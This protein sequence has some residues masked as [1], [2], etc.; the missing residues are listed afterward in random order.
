VK[1]E[2]AAAMTV[3]YVMQTGQTTWEKD[4]RL[5]SAAGAPLTPDGARFIEDAAR[6]LSD[7]N[8]AAVY[9]SDGEAE[10]QAAR[11]LAAKLGLKGRTHPGLREIDY[12][13]W[14]GLAVSEIRRRHPK[15]YR[16]WRQAPTNVRPPGGETVEEVHQRLRRALRDI[17]KRHRRQ[18]V[19]LVLRPVALGVF[20]CIAEGANVSGLWQRV[21][22]L[23]T[24]GR[25]ESNGEEL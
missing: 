11:M 18:S 23:F 20:R 19:L 10:A 5:E 8:I 15:A 3:F 2:E 21:D 22:P 24:W 4:V 14:Q 12:G 17:V 6:D 25:Y 7:R 13:L 1:P 16:T 9:G